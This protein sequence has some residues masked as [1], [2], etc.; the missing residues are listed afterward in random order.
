ML[1]KEYVV[2][3]LVC[4]GC[5]Y[6]HCPLDGSKIHHKSQSRSLPVIDN[7]LVSYV[8]IFQLD[9]LYKTNNS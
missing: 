9:R 7:I 2:C 5:Y 4:H 1:M 8:M 3:M 6:T